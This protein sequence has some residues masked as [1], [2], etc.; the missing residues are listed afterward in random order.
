MFA[1]LSILLPLFKT[2]YQPPKSALPKKLLRNRVAQFILCPIIFFFF[3][4]RL[5]PCNSPF[6][7]SCFLSISVL[8]FC[9]DFLHRLI[10]QTQ[11]DS[12]QTY[13][14]CKREIHLLTGLGS[15]QGE[16]WWKMDLHKKA[17]DEQDTLSEVN[18]LPIN[19]QTSYSVCSKLMVFGS[20]EKA[21]KQ[22]KKVRHWRRLLKK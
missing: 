16:N 7:H 4:S 10:S 6:P 5:P 15:P 9:H 21:V 18:H 12:W 19:S 2:W 8:T 17:S 13:H 22:N 11:L 3:L 1:R 20:T 14:H